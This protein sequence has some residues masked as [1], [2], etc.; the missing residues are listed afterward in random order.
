MSTPPLPGQPGVHSVQRQLTEA[1]IAALA[2]APRRKILFPLLGWSY[3]AVLVVVGVVTFLLAG[4][5]A[6]ILFLVLIT[7]AFGVAAAIGVPLGSRLAKNTVRSRLGPDNVLTVAWDQGGFSWV[8]WGATIS[9][10]HRDV[11]WAKRAG[12]TWVIRFRIRNATDPYVIALPLDFVPDAA[13]QQ[14]RAQGVQVSG[15]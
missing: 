2:T 6:T 8:G 14:W 12:Q 1:E 4:W 11:K 3:L 7:F 15:A 10:P 5:Q 13:L 9:A